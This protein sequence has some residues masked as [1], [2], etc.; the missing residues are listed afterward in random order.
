MSAFETRDF[1]LAY[2]AA[3]ACIPNFDP[4]F[5]MAKELAGLTRTAGEMIDAVRA[6]A[7]APMHKRVFAALD[8]LRAARAGD[9]IPAPVN[10]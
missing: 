3:F 2:L 4:G 6:M 9:T 8:V 5:D 7:N 10:S 1:E